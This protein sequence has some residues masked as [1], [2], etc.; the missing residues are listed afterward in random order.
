M[1]IL[2]IT[3]SHGRKD[4]IEKVIKIETPNIIISAGDYCDDLEDIQYIYEDISFYI[5]RGNCDF[6]NRK[7]KDNYILD[8]GKKI[9]ITHGHLYG[10]KSDMSELEREAERLNVDCVCFGHTHIPYRVKKK[11]IEY[12][13]P[14]ALKDGYYGIIEIDDKLELNIYNVR[15]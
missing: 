10:V 13:N 9:F 1:K 6:I 15:L 14:G 5:V 8:I 3:D 4:I 7:Y 12:F 11:Y 2:V